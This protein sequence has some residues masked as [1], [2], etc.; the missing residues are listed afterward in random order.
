MLK[1]GE[2]Y[3]FLV[4]LGAMMRIVPHPANFTPI[5]GMAVWMGKR[6]MGPLV[7]IASMI[8]SDLILGFDSG[9]M[10]VAVYG[11][12]LAMYVAGKKISNLWM[13]SFVGS[14]LFFAITNIAMWSTSS[15]YEKSWLGLGQCLY[16]ALP[17]WRNALIADMLFAQL[18]R[19][20]EV[21]LSRRVEAR[22]TS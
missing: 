14:F 13:A 22:Y 8:L 5:G 4:L 21:R 20:A 18:F 9:F 10:R 19:M 17:F 7:P 6:K 3:L 1:T 2:K 11:S 15:L 16:L 12:F